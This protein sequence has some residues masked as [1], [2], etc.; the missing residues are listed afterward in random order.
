[1]RFLVLALAMIAV[2]HSPR[3]PA[4]PSTIAVDEINYL[5]EFID[6]SG[7]KFLRNGSWYDAHRAQSHLR[8]K[9]DFLAARDRIETA[10]DFIEQA[11]TRS[12]MSGVEYQIQCGTGPALPSNRWLHTA[13]LDYR[14]STAK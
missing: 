14:S 9:Y 8:E 11:A 5:L 3:A 12:S 6:R 13:L 10:D 2:G 1:M 4:A 7:C